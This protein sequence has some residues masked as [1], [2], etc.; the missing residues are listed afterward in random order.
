MQWVFF[1]CFNTLVDDFDAE[2]A[3]DGL[4]TIAHLP[5]AAG[6]FESQ[7]AFRSAYRTARQYNWWQTNS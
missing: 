7:A 2:G 5:V 4:E 1:D 6:L 3:I